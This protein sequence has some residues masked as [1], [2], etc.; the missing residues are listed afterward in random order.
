MALLC[1]MELQLLVKQTAWVGI[2]TLDISHN[3]HECVGVV[4]RTAHSG[5]ADTGASIDA[6][7]RRSA[8]GNLA[9]HTHTHTQSLA[10]KT[11][12]VGF[13]GFSEKISLHLHDMQR[14]LELARRASQPKKPYKLQTMRKV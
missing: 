9:T 1:Q 13:A 2:Q 3:Q 10:V 7:S 5:A 6:S 8:A 14:R 12:Q 11:G 4:L